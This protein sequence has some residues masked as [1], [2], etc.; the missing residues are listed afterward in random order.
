MI[1]KSSRIKEL[2]PMLDES[3]VLRTDKRIKFATILSYS[4][5]HPI[6]IPKR[7]HLTDIIIWDYHNSCQHQFTNTVINNILMK[8]WIPS[9]KQQVRK[10][11]KRC[12]ECKLRKAKTIET[13]M[14]PILK[15]G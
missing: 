10:I 4:R 6:I 8:F 2:S 5:K 14:A 15:K 12:N 1:S 9:I 7:H 13:Q 11:E 3:G